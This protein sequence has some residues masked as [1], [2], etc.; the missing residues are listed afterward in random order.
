M[1]K[2]TQKAL[3]LVLF[4]AL[5]CFSAYAQS[6]TIT[7]TVVDEAGEPIIGAY[8]TYSSNTSV[9]AITDF[10]GE[11]EL[12]VPGKDDLI[13]SYTGYE[14]QKVSQAGKKVLNVTLKEVSTT[15]NE[16]VAIGYGSQTK[17]ELTGSVTSVK[18]ENFN[19]GSFNSTQGLLQGKVAG[20]SMSKS[21]GNDPANR[22]YNVQIRG[23]G[24]LTGTTSPLYIIDGVPGASMNN[25]NPNDIE[26]MDVLKDGSAA[27][28]VTTKKGKEGKTLVEYNGSVRTDMVNGKINVLSADEYVA[29]G[30]VNYGY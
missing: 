11:F 8:I 1:I 4:T 9:G 7:G 13:F 16:I 2:K 28:I 24:S 14:T 12:S 17:K 6:S 26:S 10:D 22:D 23:T 15:L 3:W 25:V 20:L 27:A 30:G 18:S 29:R 5:S 19:Q 21:G